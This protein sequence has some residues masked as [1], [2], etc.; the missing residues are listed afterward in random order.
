MTL[1]KDWRGTIGSIEVKPRGLGG[2]T[3][4]VQHAYN[5]VGHM[6]YLGSGGRQGAQLLGP[7]I[8][9]HV[10]RLVRGNGG[11]AGRAGCTMPISKPQGLARRA[12]AERSNP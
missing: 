4:D 10:Q 9:A 8:S 6:L 2:W 7:V 5:P 12:V 3:L 11:R 1:W